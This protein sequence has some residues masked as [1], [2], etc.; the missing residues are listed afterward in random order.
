MCNLQY[1]E[2][3]GEIDGVWA[4]LS[5]RRGGDARCVAAGA[6]NALALQNRTLRYQ[7]HEANLSSTRL[8]ESLG[9]TDFVNIEHSFSRNPETDCV[10]KP[11]REFVSKDPTFVLIDLGAFQ[12]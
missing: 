3:V 12:C 10:M 4:D 9:L 8:A 2:P 5:A 7:V 11:L 6:R 1:H